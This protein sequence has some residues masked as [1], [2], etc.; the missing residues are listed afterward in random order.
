MFD[1]ILGHGNSTDDV[2]AALLSVGV[3]AVALAIGGL[4]AEASALQEPFPDHDGANAQR[5][6][7]HA[8]DELAGGQVRQLLVETQHE[9]R[10]DPGFSEQLHLLVHADQVF[11]AQFRAQQGERV[12][13]ERDRHDARIAGR[14][15]HASPVEHGTVPRVH[16]VE[17]ADRDNRRAE[18]RGHFRRV[19]EDDHDATAV[20]TASVVVGVAGRCVAS[21]QMPKNGSTRGTNR[22]PAPNPDQTVG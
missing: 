20:D 22:Y 6:H 19:A 11:G 8:L 18:V 10:V 2:G 21:H 9:R 13:V 5:I 12:A 15:I 3:L 17:L 4:F 1:A 14:G 16:A 7:Q